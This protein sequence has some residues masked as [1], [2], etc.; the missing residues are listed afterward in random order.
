M[1]KKRSMSIATEASVTPVALVPGRSC[2]GCAM[3]CKIPEIKALNKPRNVWCTHCSTRQKCDIY[4]DRPQTCHNFNCAYLTTPGIGEE[5]RPI[6]S[7]MM[8]TYTPDGK[9]LFVQVDPSRPDAWRKAPYH[10]QLRNWARINNPQ[11]Q[12]IIVNIDGRYI[13]IYPDREVDLGTVS[14][15]ETVI[16][17]VNH[18]E[19]GPTTTAQKVKL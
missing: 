6:T 12:Q 4:L 18:T 2:E 10:Q 16:F 17:T 13:V 11:G 15:D 1:E 3:C 14:E 19:N 8:I 7:R 5:W 9:H